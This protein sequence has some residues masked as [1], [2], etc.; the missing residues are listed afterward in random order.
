MTEIYDSYPEYFW[1]LSIYLSIKEI[2]MSLKGMV[3]L[4]Y[5]S[6]TK[7]FPEVD[8]KSDEY[9]VYPGSQYL[10]PVSR[11]ASAGRLVTKPLPDGSIAFVLFQFHRPSKDALKVLDAVGSS[12]VPDKPVIAQLKGKFY[13]MNKSDALE[14]AKV[15]DAVV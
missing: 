2:F 5:V 15:L 7:D 14:A 11:A 1:T 3:Q 9:L 12:E 10:L 13:L 8:P 6:D 4:E